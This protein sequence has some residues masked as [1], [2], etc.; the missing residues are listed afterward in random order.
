MRFSVP[1]LSSS[2]D[3]SRLLTLRPIPL[4]SDLFSSIRQDFSPCALTCGE[5]I[6]PRDLRHNFA[7]VF[8]CSVPGDMAA[9]C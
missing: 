6:A 3:F 9:L 8:R 2:A 5:A 7:H 1:L 4:I